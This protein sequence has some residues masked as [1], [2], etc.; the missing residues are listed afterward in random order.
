MNKF[1]IWAIIALML[2]GGC[3]PSLNP[4]YTAKELVFDPNVVGSWA[5]PGSRNQ[6]EFTKHD[7]NSYRL[8]YTEKDGKQGRFIAHLA[9]IDGTR[10][11]DLFPE[12]M[13]TDAS[14]FHSFH[15]VPIHTIYRVQQTEPTLELAAIDYKW[16]DQ[17]L[18]DHPD[19]VQFAT[20]GNRKLITAPTEDVQAFVLEH[21]DMFTGKIVLERLPDGTN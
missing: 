2:M 18:T 7:E 17:Y 21:K 10:F 19:A 9:E 11:L 8:I 4:I 14:G 6:W 15:V 5:Q 3:V 16:L 20:F 12:Q 13:D 1:T